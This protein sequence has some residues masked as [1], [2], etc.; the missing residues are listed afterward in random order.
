MPDDG[1]P[2]PVLTGRE[3]EVLLLLAE[4]LRN[5]GIAQA[6]SIS[7]LTVRAHVE[8]IMAKLEAPTRTAAVATA[9]RRHLIT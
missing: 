6:L 5:E 9:L 1:R 7:P 2:A 4:G 3:H 8:N